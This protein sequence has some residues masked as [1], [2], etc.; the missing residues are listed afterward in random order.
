M[1]K[2][3]NGGRC[4]KSGDALKQGTDIYIMAENFSPKTHGFDIYEGYLFEVQWC[5]K[6][7]MMMGLL[8]RLAQNF[9]KRHF[10]IMQI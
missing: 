6:I 1:C 5:K 3:G 7:P 4:F 8:I 10:L 2:F 9:A